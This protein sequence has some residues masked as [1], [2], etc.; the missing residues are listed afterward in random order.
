MAE[1]E[2]KRYEEKLS[3]LNNYSQNLNT[4]ANMEAIYEMTLEAAEKAL[5]FEFADILIIE[6]KML[7]LV[8]HRGPSRVT[9]LKLPLDGDKG[10]TVKAAKTGKPV[11]IPDVSKEKAYVEGGLETRSELAA[12]IMI[13]DKV[14]GVLNVES[15]ELNAFN[16]KDR[17]LLETLAS[18]AATAISNLD[19]TTKLETSAQEIRESQQRFE[20]LFMHN[21]EAAVHLDSTFHILNVNPRFCELFGYS[22]DEVKGKHINDVI[23]QKDRME[24][25]ELLD[26]K[27]IQGY[28]YHDTVRRRKDGSLVSVSISVAPI[29]VE[30]RLLGCVAMYKDISELKNIEKKLEA[31]N[32]KL[33][34]VGS[35]TRHDARNKLSA[36]TGN[37]HLARKKLAGNEEV[38]DN[39]KEMESAV[40]Q[41]VKIFDF[42]KT[43]EMIGVEELRYT[44][45]EKMIDEAVTLFSDL[46]G[47]KVINNCSGLTVLADSLLRQLFYNLVDNSL[48]YGEKL[49]QIT[50]R[51]EKAEG[52]QIRLVYED[53]GVGV[54]W[55]AKPK[56]FQEG[57]TAGKGSGYG[58]YLV[59]RMMDAYGWD[60]RE[61]GT[62]GRGAC[63]TIVIP[64]T[65]EDG[66]E[67]YQLRQ[68]A[69]S[70]TNDHP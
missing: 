64:E 51:Y 46:K 35:L 68:S 22:L 30:G 48:K 43:Y 40:A 42:A 12:P 5:G 26:K 36:I 14:L 20:R 50:I 11:F 52:N 60:I 69:G 15:K 53:D 21:P 16:E 2:R 61:T 66:K 59:K 10:I 62:P 19:H 18:H 54:A 56:I 7:C 45:V 67:N 9:S 23:V 3:A 58:L 4:A 41:M 17:E 70:T 65:N 63:F 29:T 38:L 47:V 44:D 31:M 55:D 34:V 25:A 57:Y 24:E 37:V 39:L 32:E 28:V 49:S 6:G 1:K 8:T 13:G 33:R 27:A